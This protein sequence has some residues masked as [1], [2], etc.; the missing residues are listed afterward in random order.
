[1]LSKWWRDKYQ[2][3]SNHELFR[4]A[5]V[6]DLLTELYEDQFYNTTLEVYRNEK[7]EVQFVSTGDKVIDKW[8][9]DLAAGKIPDYLS[10]FTP[11]QI[12]KL[13]RMR[14]K[15]TDRFGKSIPSSAG[16][17]RDAADS[18]AQDAL[19]QGL[20]DPTKI[21]FPYQRF[22]DKDLPE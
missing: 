5:T 12:D 1:M 19:R 11:E 15:G 21:S 8:E 14:T 10:E 17:L 7:G 4:S 22:S 6:F 16:T 20:Q 13:N 18:I 2:L 9:E 3:P